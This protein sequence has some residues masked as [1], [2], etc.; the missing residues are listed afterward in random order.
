MFRM[1]LFIHPHLWIRNFIITSFCKWS[2]CL[3]GFKVIFVTIL[4]KLFRHL[5]KVS[6]TV[7]VFFLFC[8]KINFLVNYL[9]KGSAFF[10]LTCK[11]DKFTLHIFRELSCFPFLS[12]SLSFPLSL[13]LTYFLSPFICQPKYLSVVHSKTAAAFMGNQMLSE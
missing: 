5:Q 10:L 3:G 1:C 2:F 12:L 4:W 6:N 9:T 8:F 7:N 13:S 11:L